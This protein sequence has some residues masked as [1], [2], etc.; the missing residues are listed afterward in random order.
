MNQDNYCSL[1]V[2]QRLVDAGIVLETECFY[3][4]NRGMT[5][6]S[7]VREDCL[8]APCFAELW[9]E[10]PDKI[11]RQ[12]SDPELRLS[13]TQTHVGYIGG[14]CGGFQILYININPADALADLLI[15]VKE[16]QISCE[17]CAPTHEHIF[18]GKVWYSE[19]GR[20]GSVTCSI[21]GLPEI[22]WDEARA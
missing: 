3:D 8:P 14:K 19:D 9:R 12:P 13:M 6:R 11:Y 15:W 10:L 20:T 2:A 1:E 22:F 4:L 7:L 5:G 17:I 18:D 16:Q 21:C